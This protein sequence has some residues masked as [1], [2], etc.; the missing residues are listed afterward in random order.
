MKYKVLWTRTSLKQVEKL[1]KK[2]ATRIIDKV[3]DVSEDP[4][5]FVKKIAGFDLYRLRVGD[6]RV[7]MSIQ[8]NKM[9]IFVLQV[10]H[11][12]KIYKKY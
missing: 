2:T 8:K 6:Y 12:G 1:D 4:F 7:I 3:D 5:L 9:I 10:G 11:R